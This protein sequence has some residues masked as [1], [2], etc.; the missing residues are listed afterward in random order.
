MIL[1]CSPPP[2]RNSLRNTIAYPSALKPS[3]HMPFA[4]RFALK[5]MPEPNSGC[6]LWLGMLDWRGYAIMNIGGKNKKASHIALA[7]AGRPLP[8]GMFACH[9]CDLPCCVNAVHLF[10]GTHRDNM[11]DAKR[12][13]RTRG[14]HLSGELNPAAKLTAGIVACIREDRLNGMRMRDL[15][16]IYEMSETQIR[17]ILNGESWR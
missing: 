17:R 4:E 7:L 6:H 3:K 16:A 2:S 14:P 13:G 8:K 5:V 10:H 15:I 9:R 11:Q 12:K 1:S